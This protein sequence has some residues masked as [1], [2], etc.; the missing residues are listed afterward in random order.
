MLFLN[1]MFYFQ[2]ERRSASVYYHILKS[3]CQPAKFNLVFLVLITVTIAIMTQYIIS[4]SE[5]TQSPATIQPEMP[6]TLLSMDTKP[7][8]KQMIHLFVEGNRDIT[9]IDDILPECKRLGLFLDLPENLVNNAWDMSNDKQTACENIISQWLKGRGSHEI[10]W[11]KFISAINHIQYPR[12][13]KELESWI[14][15]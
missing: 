1:A 9:I 2:F 8:L 14:N 10:T 3:L 6:L 15:G 5:N 12:L 13:A 4:R 7:E 11:K